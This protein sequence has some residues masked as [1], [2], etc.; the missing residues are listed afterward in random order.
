ML[1]LPLKGR[2]ATINNIN[3]KLYGV[4][5]GMTVVGGEFRVGRTG[6]GVGVVAML[7]F[8]EKVWYIPD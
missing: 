8:S 5:R 6:S 3:C 4:L 7:L 2:G 1:P